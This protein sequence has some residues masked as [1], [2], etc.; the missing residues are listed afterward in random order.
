MNFKVNSRLISESFSIWLKN[1]RQIT[2]MTTIFLKWQQY[3]EICAKEKHF[4]NIKPSSV[5]QSEKNVSK[6]VQGSSYD[7][8]ISLET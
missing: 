2:P 4:F 7:R 1:A 5:N 6:N 3:F 8:L